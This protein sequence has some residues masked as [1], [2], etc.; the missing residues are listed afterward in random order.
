MKLVNRETAEKVK[1]SQP[2]LSNTIEIADILSSLYEKDK[3][4]ELKSSAEK[5]KQ[6]INSHDDKK[7]EKL[8]IL[9]RN[10]LNLKIYQHHRKD[11][12]IK[13]SIINLCKKYYK[14]V[15]L[16]IGAF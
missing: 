13:K 5:L 8:G 4:A 14:F 6:Y 2:K 7:H 15:D 1:M 9:I 10:Y 16:K 12:K 11:N 3:L